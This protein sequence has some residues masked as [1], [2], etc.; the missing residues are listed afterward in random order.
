M[1]ILIPISKMSKMRFA[2]VIRSLV[3]SYTARHGRAKA[4][5]MQ[6]LF[7]SLPVDFLQDDLL[8]LGSE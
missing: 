4:D 3:Q 5:F 1:G 6:S 2:K 8:F 7:S